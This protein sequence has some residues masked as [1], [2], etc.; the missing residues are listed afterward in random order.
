M[1]SSLQSSCTANGSGD[2][3]NC[4]YSL[5][6]S[7]PLFWAYL[8]MQANYNANAILFAVDTYTASM[9]N[10]SDHAYLWNALIYDATGRKNPPVQAHACALW[11][12][13]QAYNTS[14]TAGVASQTT[15]ATWN[16]STIDPSS[17]TWVNMTEIPYADFNMPSP[18]SYGISLPAIRALINR[19]DFYEAP[20]TVTYQVNPVDHLNAHFFSS[21]VVITLFNVTD[22]S[23]W[24]DQLALSMTNR[25]R[26]GGNVSDGLATDYYTGTA[27]S[28]ETYVHIRWLWLI[29]PAV[30]VGA[31]IVFVVATIVQT[32]LRGVRHWKDDPLALLCCTV[33]DDQL[34][35]ASCLRDMEKVQM[36]LTVKGER[37]FLKTNV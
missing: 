17:E 32:H 26:S 1:T 31:S 11:I 37:A 3:P 23:A 2:S 19:F 35:K 36:V 15:V 20:N 30:L 28:Q 4:T 9:Y 25:F 33:D 29:F 27:L 13:M 34:A 6:G 24:I 22:Y 8:D 14:V 12:C 21:D 7:G 10:E 18:A 5:P 16:K